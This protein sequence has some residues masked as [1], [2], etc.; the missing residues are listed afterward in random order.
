[1][2]TKLS[3]LGLILLLGTTAFA[4]SVNPELVKEIEKKVFVELD[5]MEI[6]RTAKDYVI[7]SFRIVH[8]SIKIM[9]VNG[10]NKQ[11][12]EKM[13]EKLCD[14]QVES[15]YDPGKTYNYKFTF[16]TL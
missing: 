2:R 15:N 4:G 1:M 16:D 8:G 3:L 11:L 7:V 6:N 12:K 9:E 13:I 14:L 10:S 5:G